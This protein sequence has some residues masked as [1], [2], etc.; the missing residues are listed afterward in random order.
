MCNASLPIDLGKGIFLNNNLLIFLLIFF[1]VGVLI[2][3]ILWAC[4]WNFTIFVL[5]RIIGGLCKGNVT[6]CT[7][8]IT[9]VTTTR[10]RGKGMVCTS[11]V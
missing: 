2:S 1:K 6:I 10:N 11:A 4:S 5:A 8:I 7:A 3:Y 9:D